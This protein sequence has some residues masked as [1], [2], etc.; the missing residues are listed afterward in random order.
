M[1]NPISMDE[2]QNEWEL[3]LDLLIARAVLDDDL[4]QSLLE[5][6]EQTCREHGVRLPEGL[7]LIITHADQRSMIR[8]IPS[9]LASPSFIKTDVLERELESSVFNG[10]T[11]TTTTTTTVAVEVEEVEAEATTTETSAEVAAEAVAVIIL[12]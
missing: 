12:T 3:A 1:S 10:Q 7:R 4:R 2:G 11:Q 9:G 8:E 5:Q 6:P